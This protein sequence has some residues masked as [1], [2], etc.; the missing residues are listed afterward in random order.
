MVYCS[1]MQGSEACARDLAGAARAMKI[2]GLKRRL[3]SKGT[4]NLRTPVS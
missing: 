4:S 1:G 2:V 3:S